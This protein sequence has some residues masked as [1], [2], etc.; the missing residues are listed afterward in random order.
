MENNR[1]LRSAS[2]IQKDCDIVQLYWARDVE[3]ISA[4]EAKYGHYLSAIAQNILCNPEDAEECVND[5]YLKAWNSIPPHRPAMLST[6]LG[7]LTRHLAFNRYQYNRAEKRGGGEL[8]LVLD[9]LAE[10]VSDRD[11]VEQ[12]IDRNELAAAINEFLR[13]LPAKQRAMFICRYWSS[14]SVSAIAARFGMTAGNVSVTLNRLRH[15]LRQHLIE[16]GFER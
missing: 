12:I 13:R 6:F 7:K 10:C 4:T 16:R 3:A 2:Q 11:D 15:K 1:H 5:T 8:P 14:D 9:E